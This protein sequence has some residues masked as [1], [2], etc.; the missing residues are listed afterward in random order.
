MVGDQDPATPR[1]VTDRVM[2]AV[3]GFLGGP[4]PCEDGWTFDFGEQLESN[5]GAVYGGALAAGCL[6]VARAAAPEQSPR[7]LHIQ[8]VR[9]VPAGRTYATAE[10]RHAGRTVG[11]VQ[12]DLF[13]ERRKLAA[14][15]LVTM[16]T[17]AAVA[18]DVHLTRVA[19]PFATSHAPDRP[20]QVFAP[21]I[22]TLRA[23]PRRDGRPLLTQ[24][25]NARCGVDGT[26]AGLVE[27]TVPWED[28]ADTGPEAACLLADMVVGHAL[29]RSPSVPSEVI[30][31]NPDLTLR[32][33]TAR[34]ER[35]IRAA[36]MLLSVQHGT[37][38]VGIEVHA[39][40]HQLAHGLSTSVLLAR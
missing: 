35:V 32:F 24:V 18:A 14:T 36:S 20:Q 29:A 26:S 12:V 28:L 34:A 3:R 10:V 21:I 4:H 5:W 23:G 22:E 11:T 39:G 8:M 40:E 25:D 17:P 13:D 37:T 7:S 9:S 1:D 27:C 15:A 30:G 16:V 2:S 6:A 19:P 38:T 31:P 33:T